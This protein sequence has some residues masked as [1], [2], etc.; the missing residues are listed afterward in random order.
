MTHARFRSLG[1][2]LLIGAL[3]LVFFWKIV[4]TN[5]ILVGVDSFLYFY[6]YKA[7][8]AQALRAGRFPLWNPHLF[9]GV[10]LF[11]NMQT[12][13]LYPLHW[14]FLWLSAPKQVAVSIVLHVMLAGWGTLAYA[15]RSLKLSWYG[16]LTV[17][18]VFALGGFV[19]AQAEHVNQLNTIAWLAWAFLLLDVSHGSR[20]RLAAM[21]GL[22]LVVALMILAG[23]A[24]ATYICLAGLGL[25]AIAGGWGRGT[26]F[27]S[28]I[29]N[30]KSQISNRKSQIANHK[31]QITNRKSQI[32]NHQSQ[33]TNRK[34]HCLNGS[35]LD[36]RILRR[37]CHISACF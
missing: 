1:A 26:V 32:A 18:V 14:P 13:V 34:P 20:R 17:A 35:L 22:G 28:Q 33:V 21:L 30:H 3:V 8:V 15:R 9:M 36:A 11:A 6:P 24:Q 5:L 10:P 12:A 31:S 29:A 25:Y 4:F 19:G 7:Y 23:H 37:A 16:A 2:G 27:K